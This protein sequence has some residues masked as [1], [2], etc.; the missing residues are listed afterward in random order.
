MAYEIVVCIK[1]VPDTENLTGEA[2]KQDGTVNRSAL[3]MICNPEDLVALE[4][5]LRV[6]E[7]GGGRVSVVTMGAPSA[8]EVLRQAL[9][10][11]ADRVILLTDRKLAASD[12]LATGY[13]LSQAIRKL[14]QPDLVFCGRQAIDGDTAQTGPQLAEKLGL[15]RITYV[16][17]ILSL[18]NGQIVARRNLEGGYEV[19]RASLPV[20]LTVVGAANTPRPP[21]L[22]RLLKYRKAR[23]PGEQDSKGGA[24]LERLRKRGLLVEQWG[25]EDV[26]CDLNRIGGSGSPTKVKKIES[27]KLV[28]EQRVQVE[29]TKDGLVTLVR[30]LIAEHILE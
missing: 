1:Y 13:A 21:A 23:A 16:E 29:P 25:A 6:K 18:D 11:G 14:P 19:V 26:G 7:Q 12:T 8:A 10:R 20:L 24:D 4:M 17:Q 3:P 15:P 28:S 2:M 30:G 22:K 27:V 9:Y 5:A